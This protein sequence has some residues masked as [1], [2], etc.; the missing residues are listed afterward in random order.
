MYLT[1]HADTAGGIVQQNNASRWSQ[2][3]PGLPAAVAL[4]GHH[5]QLR[6]ASTSAATTSSSSG[7]FSR[8]ASRP[9]P[10]ACDWCFDLGTVSEDALASRPT[11]SW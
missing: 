11:A 8:S 5:A 3:A 6:P 9:I 10:P 4:D 7:S 1:L 2:P